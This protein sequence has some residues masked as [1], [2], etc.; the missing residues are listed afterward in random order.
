MR[1]RQPQCFPGVSDKK[2]SCTRAFPALRRN[3]S[4]D[5]KQSPR[6][7]NVLALKPRNVSC[8]ASGPKESSE[9]NCTTS[10][11]CSMTPNSDAHRT[12][13]APHATSSRRSL[14][15]SCRVCGKEWICLARYVRNRFDG[16]E[17][18]FQLKN[19]HTTGGTH[20][21]DVTLS[22][23]AEP[24]GTSAVARSSFGQAENSWR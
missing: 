21:S 12:W 1:A 10:G 15:Q 13:R 4:R 19:E 16:D 23:R 7:S 18:P 2:C 5:G 3:V 14:A 24:R 6:V 9:F 17:R 8:Q 22:S 20:A 11:Q